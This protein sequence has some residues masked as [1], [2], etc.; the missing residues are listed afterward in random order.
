MPFPRCTAVLQPVTYGAGDSTRKRIQWTVFPASICVFSRRVPPAR[1]AST[2]RA[3]ISASRRTSPRTIS[4]RT[5]EVN[6]KF[7]GRLMQAIADPRHRRPDP[8]AARAGP[9]RMSE[10]DLVSDFRAPRATVYHPVGPADGPQHRR[11]GGR[12]R[13]ARAR[14]GEG[15]ASS[16]PRC[17]RRHVGQ[18]QRTDAHGRARAADTSWQDVSGAL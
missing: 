10:A 16:T 13:A 5:V 1:A 11:V 18:H 2:S 6:A 15:C 8:R 17:S 14:H 3:P 12:P 4:P 9:V 7:G